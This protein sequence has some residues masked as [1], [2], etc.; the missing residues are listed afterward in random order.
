MRGA[1]GE[2]EGIVLLWV[3]PVRDNRDNRRNSYEKKSFYKNS[4]IL[5]WRTSI[6]SLKAHSIAG[7]PCFTRTRFVGRP[8]I[9]T[10][11]SVICFPFPHC[12]VSNYA[13]GTNIRVVVNYSGTVKTL[14][15]STKHRL[16]QT[17]GLILW[18]TELSSTPGYQPQV[19]HEYQ[20][21]WRVHNNNSWQM[22]RLIQGSLHLRT[23]RYLTEDEID[24][25]IQRWL[26][27]LLLADDIVFTAENPQT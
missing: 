24:G 11:L 1:R 27:M 15:C 12:F 2:G 23:W 16:S 20:L 19:A 26:Q 10:S 18:T 21:P 8:S 22:R 14:H 25:G 3:Y 5:A 13:A 7:L 4:T 9:W 6:F 17:R